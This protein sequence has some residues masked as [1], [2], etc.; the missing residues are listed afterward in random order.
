MAALPSPEE[1][2][3]TSPRS[4]VAGVKSTMCQSV[5][6]W[7]RKKERKKEKWE[8]I[9]FYAAWVSDNT[10]PYPILAWTRS[11]WTERNNKPQRQLKIHPG[12]QEALHKQESSEGLKKFILLF[13]LEEG[14]REYE[15]T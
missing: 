4:G 15:I 5:K 1:V 13:D 7:E 6:D 10:L 3:T 12:N 8:V 11:V 2:S 9:I 14:E